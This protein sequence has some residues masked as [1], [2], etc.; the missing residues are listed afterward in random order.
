MREDAHARHRHAARTSTTSPA[1]AAAATIAG[2]ISSVRPV[3]LPC[4]PL[5][6]RFDDD[7][8][9]FAAVE[10]IGVHRQAHRAAGAAP[11]E[12]G[13]A[14]R[15]RRAPR[16]RRRARTACDPG[17]TSARTCG[18]TRWPAHDLRR[19]RA[20]PTAGR[21]CTTRRTRRRSACRRSAG[22]AEAH[23]LE[24]FADARRA[25]RRPASPGRGKRAST[26]TDWPGLMPHVTVGAIA[27]ASITT[28]SSQ[29]RVGDPRP[30]SATRRARDRTPRPAA[31]IAGP[32]RYSNVVSSGFT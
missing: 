3:G 19:P 8:Q 31:R 30:A 11:V 32:R 9:I 27:A 22:R 12:A 18:A 1:I 20:G 5:K 10:S 6:L 23:E 25:R 26:P 13:V 2:L 14:K 29:S 16:A 28:S 4:R 21:S 15:S 7:A 17:T 24:R